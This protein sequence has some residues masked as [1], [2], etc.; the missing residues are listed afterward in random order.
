M[1]NGDELARVKQSEYY[2]AC[3]RTLR[4][5]CTVVHVIL[6]IGFRFDVIYVCVCV[7]VCE[8]VNADFVVLNDGPTLYFSSYIYPKIPNHVEHQTNYET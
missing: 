2:G 8:R 7:C 5:F 4:H 3:K 1:R 6:Y